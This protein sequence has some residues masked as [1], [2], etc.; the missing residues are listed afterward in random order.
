[1]GFSHSAWR[2]CGW[3]HRARLLQFP[4]PGNEV[5]V[6][7]Y[8]MAYTS[9]A[10]NETLMIPAPGYELWGPAFAGAAKWNGKMYEGLATMGG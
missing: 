7:S 4:I 8:P 10:S 5:K 3:Q 2:L 9:K 1:M 6:W